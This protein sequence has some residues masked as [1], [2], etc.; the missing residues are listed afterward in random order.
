M[1]NRTFSGK[2]AR[3]EAAKALTFTILSW[4][5]DQTMQPRGQFRG[6]EIL[7]KGKN[8]GFGLLQEAARVPELFIR[9]RAAYSANLNPANPVGTVQSIEHTL[10]SL[11][12]LAAEQQAR[13]TRAEKELVDYSAQTDRPFEHGERLKQLLARQTEL[14]SQLDLDKGDQQG[15][16][17]APDISGELDREKTATASSPPPSELAKKAEE[18]MRSAGTAIRETPIVQRAPPIAGSITARAVAKDDSHVAFATAANRFIVVELCALGREVRIGERLSLQF[19]QG[20][21]FIDSDLGRG[22]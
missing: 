16:D 2:G 1:V 22:R 18:N 4:R 6:F 8:D 19:S 7:S 14:N 21:A 20:R 12:K 9:G 11:D 3:E 10:R 15:A 13:V 5:D 17:S